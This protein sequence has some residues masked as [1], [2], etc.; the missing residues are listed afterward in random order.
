MSSLPEFAEPQ[1]RET[2]RD[3]LNFAEFPLASLTTT[4]PKGQK[5]LEFSDEI[6][7]KARRERVTRK[8][9][10]TASDKYGLPTATDDEVILGLIQLSARS[11]FDARRVYFTRY[12]LL[13]LLNWS[14]DSRNY[15]R[16]EESLNRWLGV[17]LYYD[18]SWWSKEEQSW[19]S[20]GFHI[21]DQVT[22]LDKERRKRTTGKPEAG[23]SSFVWNELV[24][25]SFKSGY[26]KQIDFK[27]YKS[28]ESAVSK[29]I[30]RF[31]D[32]RFYHRDHLEFDLRTFACEHIGLSKKYHNGELKR[33]LR[34]AIE[35][36]EESGFLT[37]AT[38]EERFVKKVRGEWSIRFQRGSARP[39]LEKPL[40]TDA[41]N[42]ELATLL[43]ARGLTPKAAARVVGKS[44]ES[45]IREKIALLDWLVSKKD[46][47]VERSP[48][49]FLYRAITEDF[50]LPD[51]Y[52]REL[53]KVRTRVK[54]VPA[55]KTKKTEERTPTASEISDRKRID[56]YWRSLPAPEQERIE[57][58][59]VEKS[60]RFLR[61][62]YMEGREGR[63]VLFQAFRQAM[64]DKYVRELMRQKG[65][66]RGGVGR[67]AR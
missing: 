32:K 53:E 59:L 10:I 21:L 37:T 6:F 35:E 26:L 11:N 22:I 28:L 2:Y 13:K 39:A 47:R 7:D 51:D 40:E 43:V 12:E 48:A 8:L 41:K 16:I 42:H 36:L 23:K 63:G 55:A 58:E 61:E 4:L 15:A 50:P 20:E 57:K 46:R 54:A 5:T 67:E 24:F 1:A 66:D 29:R 19:V 25:D 65:E 18:K 31:L 30:Y 49:G 9:T 3:E 44:N 56:E 34:P 45:T 27:F 52:R 17:T 64:I 60:P 62:Q 14:D 33:V 38:A